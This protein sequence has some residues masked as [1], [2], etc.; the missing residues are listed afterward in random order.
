MGMEVFGRKPKSKIG[1]FFWNDVWH[2]RPL[3]AYC[4]KVAADITK[5]WEMGHLN[6]GWGLTSKQA[7]KLAQVLEKKLADGSVAGYAEQSEFKGDVYP[8]PDKEII[9]AMGLRP[10]EEDYLFSKENVQN[11]LAFLKDCGGF[12]IW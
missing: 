3:W 2:W 11:F 1:E 9:K 10:T 8:L 6:D 7:S 4:E 5:Q 12:R